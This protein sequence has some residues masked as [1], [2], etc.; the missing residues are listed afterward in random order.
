[1]RQSNLTILS[2][3][4][5]ISLKSRVKFLYKANFHVDKTKKADFTN[6]FRFGG[7]QALRKNLVKGLDYAGVEFELSNRIRNNQNNIGLLA[8]KELL[9]QLTRF[10]TQKP[11][12]IV[13]GPNLF[14]TPKGFETELQ[15]ELVR[16]VVVPSKWVA[17]L[18]ARELPEISHKIVTWAVGIDFNYW[19]PLKTKRDNINNKVVIYVKCQDYLLIDRVKSRLEQNGFSCVVTTYGMYS[20]NDYLEQLQS[21]VALVYIGKSESQGIALLE[22]WATNVPT[23]VYNYNEVVTIQTEF[24]VI[25]LPKNSYSPAPYLNDKRGL[26]WSD[27]NELESYLRDLEIYEPRENSRIFSAEICALNYVKLFGI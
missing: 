21:S 6:D 3:N 11:R 20:E 18:W 17:D 23:F 10:K 9:R 13:V 2:A 25:D 8:G 4:D 7:H 16:K 27:L 15:S 24:G 22:A 1:M 14:I 5:G 12:H 26:F 19:I